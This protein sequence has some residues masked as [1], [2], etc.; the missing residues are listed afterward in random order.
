MTSP[1]S[2][3]LKTT[4]PDL[5]P[6]F[7][8]GVA[9]CAAEILTFPIDTAKTRLQLQGQTT[10]AHHSQ[11][12]YKGIFHCWKTVVKEEGLTVLYSG[13]AP[14]LLRQAIYGTI[15]YGLYYTIKDFIGGEESPVKNVSI[16]VVAG[17]LSA[18]IANPTDVLKVSLQSR[19]APVVSPK[20]V[21]RVSLYNCFRDIYVREGISGLWRGVAPTASRAALVAGV[22]LP[23]YDMIKLFMLKH[24]ILPGDSA[25]NHL[26]SSFCAGLCSCLVSSPVDVVRTRL[27]DQRTL[28]H[29]KPKTKDAQIIYKSSLQCGLTT[30]RNEGF[31]AL[32]KGF[33]ASFMRMGPWNII[34]FLVYEQLKQISSSRAF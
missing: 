15:K 22:Q 14:A 29:P 20:R 31:L 17:S 24:G 9:S 5:K 3:P 10:D 13:L 6:F 11:N 27:M 1:A 7:F 16:A 23:V 25:W 34:F 21:I 32:Y 33:V 2:D 30:L 26:F 8:G 18:S 28:L 19:S 12:R 4:N